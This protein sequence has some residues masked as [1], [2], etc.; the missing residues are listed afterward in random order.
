[1]AKFTTK[2]L[3]DIK[4]WQKQIKPYF[5]KFERLN[6]TAKYWN[7]KGH[8]AVLNNYAYEVSDL[9]NYLKTYLTEYKY[10]KSKYSENQFGLAEKATKARP[11]T[12]PVR[13]KTT[14]K[15]KS[16]LPARLK[17]KLKNKK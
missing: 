10:A 2:D 8:M 16:A 4:A 6:T 14:V 9:I 7:T 15:S 3:Q 1:M 5:K 11:G 12:K 17:T 13:R